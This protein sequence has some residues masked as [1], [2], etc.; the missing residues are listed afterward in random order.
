MAIGTERG[1]LKPEKDGTAGLYGTTETGVQ[2][3][4]CK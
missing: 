3:A 2:Y 4:S 1:A